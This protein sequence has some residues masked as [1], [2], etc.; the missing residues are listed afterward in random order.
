M[1]YATLADLIERA[2]EAEIRQV[3][4]RDRDGAIDADVIEAALQDADNLVNGYVA[5]KYAVP[6]ASVPDLVRTWAV[7]IA[8]Y[9][10]H[11]NGAP[12]HV[13]Q[14]YKDAL[15][16]LKDVAAGRLTLPVAPGEAALSPVSG[17]VMGSHPPPVFTPDKLRGW[18]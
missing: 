11:R 18:R 2:G 10:L 5:T 3:A 7:S 13:E 4:D 15:A 12:D 16:A 14:D 1:P 8:R 17:T 6:L 9:V